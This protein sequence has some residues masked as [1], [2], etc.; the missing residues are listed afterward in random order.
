MLLQTAL[1]TKTHPEG[2]LALKLWC[3]EKVELSLIDPEG[4]CKLNESRM[5][6]QAMFPLKV[7]V[8]KAASSC[9]FLTRSER[10][11]NLTKVFSYLKLNMF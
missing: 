9:L 5:E 7:S 6:G 2:A 1:A 10:K 4:T 8:R 11:F 3:T